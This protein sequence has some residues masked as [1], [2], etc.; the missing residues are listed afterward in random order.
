MENISHPGKFPVKIKNIINSEKIIKK[1]STAEAITIIGK[2]ILGKLIF[3]IRFAL[4]IK[5]P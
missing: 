4:L 1:F 5:T 2:H 3:F